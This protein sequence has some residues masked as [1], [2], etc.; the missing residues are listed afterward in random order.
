MGKNHWE[1]INSKIVVLGMRIDMVQIP[2]V[3][4][5]IENWIRNKL[6]GNYISVSNVDSAIWSRKNIDFRNAV[7]NSSLSV[8]DGKALVLL[9][10]LYGYPLKRRVYGPELMEEFCKLANNRGY[11]NYFYGGT[12]KTLSKLTENLTVRF[13]NLKISGACSPPFRD[14]TCEE[15]RQIIETINKAKP[16]VLWVGIGCPKQEIWM[17]EHKD[18]LNVAAIVGVGAAFDFH[19]GTKKQAP[20]WMREHG[21][22]WFFR[23]ITEPRRLWKRYIVGGAVFI[24]NIIPDLARNFFL[25]E[26]KMRDELKK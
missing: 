16:D 19:A 26:K 23:L 4:C 12:N 11:T 6:F 14:L 5:T 21:L 3:L 13:P 9:A 24:Y 18:K 25:K 7:N 22:E 1:I 2:D 8:P 15:D 20:Y 17:Y 10:R